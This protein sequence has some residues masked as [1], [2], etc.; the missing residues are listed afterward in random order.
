MR[1]AL[2]A[3]EYAFINFFCN[4]SVVRDQHRTTRAAERLVSREANHVCKPNR[5]GQFLGGNQT[6][7]VGDV[8][9]QVSPNLIGDAAESSPIWHPRVGSVTG[10]DHFRRTFP[11][12]PSDLIVVQAFCDRVDRVMEG[13]VKQTGTVDGRAM[14]QVAAMQ[15]I[16]SQ[17]VIARFNQGGIDRRVGRCAR[18]RLHVHPQ[19]VCAKI[20]CSE[21]LSSAALGQCFHNVDIFH[22]FV[23]ALIAMTAVAAELIGVI[24][25][26]F[27]RLGAGFGSGIAFGVNIG[28]G[29]TQKL[30]YRQRSCALTG[31]HNQAA[32]LALSFKICQLLQ[33]GVIIFQVFGEQIIGHGNVLKNEM[34]RKNRQFFGLKLSLD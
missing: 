25:N 3:W 28:E 22:A 29:R 15:Q 26:F 31:D 21:Q 4:L 30:A 19:V 12:N 13:I 27:L 23:I 7:N 9:Q 33:I 18:K 11:R 5:R 2:L 34:G 14:G 10:Y 20:I 17:N 6:G 8:C 1:A 32:G 24:Q 16:H